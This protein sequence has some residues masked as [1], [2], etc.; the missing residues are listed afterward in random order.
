MNPTEK[1]MEKMEMKTIE[2]NATGKLKG[3]TFTGF[4]GDR[5][6]ISDTRT[7]LPAIKKA[8]SSHVEAVYAIETYYRDKITGHTV[9]VISN[10]ILSS[11]TTK[12]AKIMLSLLYG[13]PVRWGNKK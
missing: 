3:F 4:D 1:G 11:H 9:I 6:A 2:I 7:G 5:W 10:G 8:L 13:H 12:S